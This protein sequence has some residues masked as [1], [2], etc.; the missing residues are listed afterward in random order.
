MGLFCVS[1][2]QI[3]PLLD[4]FNNPGFASAGLFLIKIQGAMFGFSPAGE[5]W[6]DDTVGC[7]YVTVNREACLR[8]ATLKRI[9]F[10]LLVD[11]FLVNVCVRVQSTGQMYM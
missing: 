3:S 2:I 6:R 8:R 4:K 10:A 9:V 1:Y 11:C 7:G 5:V